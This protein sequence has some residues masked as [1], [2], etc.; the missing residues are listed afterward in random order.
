MDKQN[1][2]FGLVI[3]LVLITF[4]LYR[5]TTEYMDKND[6]E[7]LNSVQI[8][9]NNF[10]QGQNIDTTHYIINGVLENNDVIL[11][12]EFAKLLNYKNGKFQILVENLI[13]AD[14]NYFKI[15]I[16]KGEMSK[17]F[18]FDYDSKFSPK[19]KEILKR[20]AAEEERKQKISERKEYLANLNKFG[21]KAARIKIRHPEWSWEDCKDIANHKIWIGMEIDMLIFM[22]GRNFHKNV[23]N[24]GDGN[25]Y[26]YCWID[27]SPS[28]FYDNDGDGK[29][30]SYN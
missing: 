22:R 29:I 4:F 23:S 16:S 17:E 2:F 15:K 25:H 5:T 11:N 18:Q 8:K 14:K 27:Y 30:E 28:C 21:K 26:Q 19:T 13:E 12:V 1:K 20:I 24:Y 7:Y 6:L 3:I 9:F 10:R